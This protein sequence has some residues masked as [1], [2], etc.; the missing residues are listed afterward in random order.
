[1]LVLR[2][3]QAGERKEV[4]VLIA[5][6]ADSLAM[7][8]A[9]DPED[10]HALMDGFF[11][12]AVEGIHREGGTVN[13][14]RGDGFMALFGAP[15][16]RG[17]DAARALRAALE[18]RA[19]ARDYAESVRARYG[20]SFSVR[21]GVNTG[22]V[23]VGAIGTDLRRDYT[24]EGP[25]AGLASRLE[26]E[27]A[28]WQ[29]LVGQATVRRCADYFELRDLGPRELRG[30]VDPVRV[31]EL[32]REGRHGARLAVERERG[33]TPFVGR[34]EELALLRRAFEAG[35]GV[36]CLEVRGEVGVGKSRLVHELAQGV[37]ESAQRLELCCREADTRRAYRPWLE[38]LRR[39]PEDL[40]GGAQA[41]RLVR[42]LE[43]REAHA[44]DPEEV[45]GAVRA[46]LRGALGERPLLVL[47]D[48]A[49][50]LDPSS[51]ALLERLTADPP[52]GRLAFVATRRIEAGSAWSP[53]AP[54]TSL[55][56]GPLAGADARRLARSLLAS[57]EN[58]DDLAEL[59]CLR[60][61]GNPLFVEEVARA[62]RDGA[63]SL[64]D[65]ARAELALSRARERI[66]ETL[67]AVVAARIDA[68]PE[69]CKRLLE[70][71]AVIGEPFT[72]DLLRDL[73]PES[74]ADADALL[75]ELVA[76]GL[77]ARSPTATY[78]FCHGVVESGA[79]A[80]L[81]RERRGAL[82]RRVAEAAEKQPCAP[83]PEGASRIGHHYDRAGDVV[84]AAGHLLRA[85]RGY[86]R[87]RALPEAVDHL[88]RALELVR[89]A[90]ARDAPLE[91]SVGLALAGS[92]AAQDRSGEA[93]AV[94]ETLDVE[95][96]DPGDRLP[97]A[98]ARVQAGWVRFSNDNE[99]RRGR[100]LI[101]QGL[102]LAEGLPGAEDVQILAF[103]HLSR[104]AVLEGE[105]ERGLAAARRMA[106]LAMAG[107]D[108]TSLAL[109][110]H[111]ESVAHG[112]A[113][114]LHEAR[115]AA[116][117]AVFEARGSE[118]PL[119]LGM[120][121]LAL[122]RV[123]LLEAD[124]E[125]ALEA[126]RLVCEAG[127][128][129]GQI[130]LRYHA[131]VVRGQAHLLAGAPREAHAAF[132][133]LAGLNERWPSTWLFRARGQLE[134]G[135]LA[136]SLASAERCLASAPPRAVRAR[137]LALRGLALGLGAG[138]RDAADASLC[139]ALDLCDAMGLQPTLAETYGYLAE[140]RARRGDARGAEAA[141]ERAEQIY[142]RSGMEALAAR[143]RSG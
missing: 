60:G 24:A 10:T 31:Y 52:E 69:K 41:A 20:L 74:A 101:E 36:R 109:A 93:A 3:S 120:A 68:L 76:R 58:A 44:P 28:P 45:A 87:L 56:L 1:M 84:A 139:E 25:T 124:V 114:R 30:L 130:G 122:A 8:D 108:A 78:D 143:L 33:L 116:R 18:V 117:E 138:A 46:L 132:E 72:V 107:G 50:W 81:V 142:R 71:A 91:A 115:R 19:R 133:T 6:V 21:I 106:E 125:G 104:I 140:V 83:T 35:S 15:R 102:R 85:G 16:A 47:V 17:D 59:A 110:R 129:S 12:L 79:Y 80:Q 37:S 11:A 49:Q 27:A 65:A 4:T 86:A 5:D 121:Q 39:W 13:Q 61:G 88:R 97:L 14:F 90:P 126:A 63:E 123:R 73:E 67:H 141:V 105:L 135:A 9:V 38:V 103:S 26:R 22:L 53:A 42:A 92:L 75:A 43:G 62:L 118:N 136:D 95:S 127:E 55:R 57:T 64:R 77:L 99:V 112:E 54:V 134:M 111:H 100:R 7:A 82:H 94:L 48:D 51:E 98:M 23:W 34:E 96:P 137:A 66:P 119:A 29:I 70:A 2:D 89:R 128:R 113:G 131:A 32:L 40:P